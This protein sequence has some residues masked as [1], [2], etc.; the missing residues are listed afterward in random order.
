MMNFY[1]RREESAKSALSHYQSLC[2]LANQ[3]EDA[4]NAV[5]RGECRSDTKSNDLFYSLLYSYIAR[6]KKELFTKKIEL[7]L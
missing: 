4:N 1:H 6:E 3:I 7:K 5:L 2:S